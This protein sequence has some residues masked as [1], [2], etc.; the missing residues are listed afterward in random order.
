[1][2]TFQGEMGDVLI[3]E[4]CL[5]L[6]DDTTFSFGLAKFLGIGTVTMSVV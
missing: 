2:P 4:D 5:P 3:D 6:N 1:M